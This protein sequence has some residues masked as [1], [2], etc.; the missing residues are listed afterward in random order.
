M[1]SEDRLSL[2]CDQTALTGIDFIQVV[3]PLI[4]TLLRVFFVVEPSALDVPMINPA[5][6]V[7]PMGGQQAGP[8]VPEGALG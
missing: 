2:L 5:V 1:A 4:Q 7:P 8:P 6:L 3:E